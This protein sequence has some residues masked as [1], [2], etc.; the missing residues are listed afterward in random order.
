MHTIMTLLEE[1]DAEE[2]DAM[3]YADCA[4]KYKDTDRSLSDMYITLARAE[5]EH[6]G[7]LEQQADRL[8]TEKIGTD[9]TG[10]IKEL[11]DWFKKHCLKK[12]DK[13]REYMDQ[14]K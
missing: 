7:K 3:K 2:H 11:Q 9:E 4:I 10:C 5:L 6:Y 14:Y 12:K 1:M 13:L 8:I